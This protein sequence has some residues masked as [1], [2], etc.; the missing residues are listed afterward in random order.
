MSI[1]YSLIL[2][3]EKNEKERSLKE[4]QTCSNHCF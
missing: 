3:G 1:N 4:K 2:M